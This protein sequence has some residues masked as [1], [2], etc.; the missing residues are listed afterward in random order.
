MP[1]YAF[2]CLSLIYMFFPGAVAL[3]PFLTQQKGWICGHEMSVLKLGI[4]VTAVVGQSK[5]PSLRWPPNQCDV[6]GQWSTQLLSYTSYCSHYCFFPMSVLTKYVWHKLQS[7]TI[8]EL[9][10]TFRLY[11]NVSRN[12]HPNINQPLSNE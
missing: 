8:I 6:K 12:P 10:Y 11:Q 3:D 7:N 5:C 1:F 2:L 9:Q 4:S